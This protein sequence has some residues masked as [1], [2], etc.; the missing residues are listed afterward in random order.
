MSG[1]GIEQ[2]SVDVYLPCDCGDPD[3]RGYR[4]SDLG[5]HPFAVP[6][7]R[8]RYTE[9]SEASLEPDTS[10]PHAFVKTSSWQF[11][12]ERTDVNDLLA[13]LWGVY[14]RAAGIAN[15][16]L[17]SEGS[18]MN[19]VYLS[20]SMRFQILKRRSAHRTLWRTGCGLQTIPEHFCHPFRTFGLRD[21][22][23]W[24][25]PRRSGK[26]RAS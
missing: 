18:V 26:S 8:S 16:A 25:R 4:L 24:S 23:A 10:L 7:Q 2:S 19:S 5:L 21:R 17:L 11:D 12:G 13:V 22:S 15:I 1:N 9:D 14:L 6:F 3:C 20:R